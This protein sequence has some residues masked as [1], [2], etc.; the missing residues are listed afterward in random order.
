VA[1]EQILALAYAEAGQAPGGDD[2]VERTLT[3]FREQT[4]AHVNAL[5]S[6]LE[7]IGFDAPDTPSDPADD[8]VFDGVDGIDSDTATELGDLLARVGEPNGINGFLPLLIELELDEIRFYVDRAST[9]DSEDLRSTCAEIAASQAQHLVVLRQANRGG[10]PSADDIKIE[11]GS[12]GGSE[13]E[14]S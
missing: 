6:A 12:S 1:R 13:A 14:G 10:G 9:L 8:G 5:T 2:A 7:S 4:Q 11:I 3:R